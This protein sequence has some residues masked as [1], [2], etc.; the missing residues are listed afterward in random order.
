MKFKVTVLVTIVVVLAAAGL[1]NAADDGPKF[2]R[3]VS[4]QFVIE[5]F[6]DDAHAALAQFFS[7]T[8]M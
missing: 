2:Q 4:L 3:N 1:A 7:D 8:V 6:V 5:G